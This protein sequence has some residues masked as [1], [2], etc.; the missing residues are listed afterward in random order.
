MVCPR[1]ANLLGVMSNDKRLLPGDF[2]RSVGLC[3]AMFWELLAC[4]TEGRIAIFCRDFSLEGD[5][6]RGKSAFGL[7]SKEDWK[8]DGRPR[9]GGNCVSSSSGSRFKSIF[10]LRTRRKFTL[11]RLENIFEP[12]VGTLILTIAIPRLHRDVG[13]STKGTDSM[14]NPLHLEEIP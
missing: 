1:Q 10:R 14:E 9:I 8:R 6:R 11:V 4:G 5:R 2:T 7:I 3:G 12:H 13:C